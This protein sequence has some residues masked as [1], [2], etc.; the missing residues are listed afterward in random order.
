MKFKVIDF[1]EINFMSSNSFPIGSLDEYLN[2]GRQDVLQNVDIF[3]ENVRSLPK[4]EKNFSLFERVDYIND[5]VILIFSIYLELFEYKGRMNE[6]L[7]CIDYYSN[8]Y[9]NNKIVVSW[10]HDNNFSKYND[11]ISKY[12]NVFVINYNTSSASQRDILCPFWSFNTDPLSEEKNK[13]CSFAGSFNTQTRANLHTT[14][15]HHPSYHFANGLNEDQYRKFISSSIFTFAPRGL[16]LSS[17]RFFE[18]I[19]LNSI[20]ILFADSV[21]LPMSDEINYNEICIR[22]PENKSTNF[23]YVNATLND[24]RNSGLSQMMQNL[25]KTRD[26]FT[27][28]GVQE[29]V[30]KH[31][32]G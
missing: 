21:C 13:F 12:N 29:Y 31:L 23:H 4:K 1:D 16:G 6:A 30:S 8:K 19:H 27:L 28:R 22:I 9:P 2:G 11:V 24:I 15:S 25:E 10:N 5:S 17:Y 7:K 18:C 3:C 32:S 14:F 20:P 26:K